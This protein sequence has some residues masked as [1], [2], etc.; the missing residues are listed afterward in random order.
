MQCN[1]AS[2]STV[3]TASKCCAISWSQS[4]SIFD[5]VISW[6]MSGNREPWAQC[7]R[8]L[9][10]IEV[11]QIPSSISNVIFLGNKV[12]RRVHLKVVSHRQCSGRIQRMYVYSCIPGLYSLGWSSSSFAAPGRAYCF[13]LGVVETVHLP[14]NPSFSRPRSLVGLSDFIKLCWMI[15][16]G[17]VFATS[18][19][20]GKALGWRNVAGLEAWLLGLDGCWMEFGDWR[21]EEVVLH[22]QCFR[23]ILMGICS[24][25]IYCMI[26]QVNVF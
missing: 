1:L 19:I 5:L 12:S 17:I 7:H 2:T 16:L 25:I 26:E 14:P 23:R 24:G 10:Y 3:R 15:T 9:M 21:L 8:A 13:S 4:K 18:G 6:V 22:S 11:F 20:C